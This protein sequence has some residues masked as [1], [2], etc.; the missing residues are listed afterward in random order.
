MNRNGRYIIGTCET[1]S[2]PS[3]GYLYDT[4]TGTTT[5]LSLVG[6]GPLSTNPRTVSADGNR[7][8]GGLTLWNIAANTRSAITPPPGAT[9][10]GINDASD[11]SSVWVGYGT[12]QNTQRVLRWVGNLPTVLPSPPQALSARAECTDAA[13]AILGGSYLRLLPA[14]FNDP[15]SERRAMIWRG[16]LG[17]IDLTEYATLTLGL[18]LSGTLLVSCNGISA[19]GR[20][21]VGEGRAAGATVSWMLR[22]PGAVAFCAADLGQQGGAVGPDG[23]LDNNDFIIFIAAFFTANARAD[24]GRTGGL[25]GRDG[26]LDNN[27]F[28]AFIDLFFQGC[29]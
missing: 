27:D 8:V 11:D 5:A 2:P 19:D 1:N 21:L 14:F 16:D 24:V 25:H 23:V 6:S 29:N 20:V 17:S 3:G 7:I 9:S 13:G 22:L 15:P 12:V 4:V 10:I 18:N 26:I 28:V